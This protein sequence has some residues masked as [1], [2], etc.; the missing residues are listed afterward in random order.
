MGHSGLVKLLD[1]CE[2]FESRVSTLERNFNEHVNKLDD[3]RCQLS[4]NSG[5]KDDEFQD[6]KKS[7]EYLICDMQTMIETIFPQ[8]S[9][10]HLHQRT[11]IPSPFE[12][13]QSIIVVEKIEERSTNNDTNG[14][15]SALST[16]FSTWLE[17][18]E[19]RNRFC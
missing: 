8:P 12:S 6:L 2:E 13:S 18:L 19:R 1:H 16:I 11:D 5:V 3:L 14:I 7:V 9:V 17:D 4:Q 10:T 15:I